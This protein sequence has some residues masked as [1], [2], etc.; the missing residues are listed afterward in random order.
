GVL[1]LAAGAATAAAQAPTATQARP[2]A[3]GA[4]GQRGAHGAWKG[5][6]RGLF[7]GIKLSADEQARVKAVREKY[8]PQLKAERKADEPRMKAI[9]EARQRGD[10]AAARTLRASMAGERQ[11]G[12][13]VMQAMQRDLR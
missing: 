12:S 3:H 2:A 5:A 9:R 1:A 13:A 10:T 7:H 8:A 6:E 4:H 11:Q